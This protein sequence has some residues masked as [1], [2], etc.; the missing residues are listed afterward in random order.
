M[1]THDNV[2]DKNPMEPPLHAK[3]K[4]REEIS[5][6]NILDGVKKIALL[7]ELS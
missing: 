1:R 6:A 3:V 2:Q 4:S 5:Q 7:T